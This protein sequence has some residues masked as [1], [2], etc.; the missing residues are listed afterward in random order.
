[1]KVGHQGGDD[2]LRTFART[3]A[4]EL[5]QGDVLFRYGGEE[6]VALLPHADLTGAVSAAE[7]L[8]KAV[9]AMSVRLGAATI[10]VTTS[11]GVAALASSD[12]DGT[13]LVARADGALYEAKRGGRNRVHASGAARLAL[14]A[15]VAS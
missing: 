4:A 2:V 1:V 5:R 9:A 12:V 3:I 14:V 8:V 15:G 10:R 13:S 7:R 6:F 11:A